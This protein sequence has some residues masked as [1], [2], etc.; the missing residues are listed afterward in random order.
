MLFVNWDGVN[1]PQFGWCLI[2]SKAQS[3]TRLETQLIDILREDQYVSL[4]IIVAD[5]GGKEVFSYRSHLSDGCAYLVRLHDAFTIIGP[6][7]KHDGLVLEVM[8]PNLSEL[9]HKRP[10]FQVGEPW[11]RRFTTAFAKRALLD[12]L[13]ALDFLHQRD[14]VHGDLHFGNILTCIGQLKVSPETES[15]LQQSVSEGHP[16]V[17]KDG[18]RDLW[19]PSH[20]LEPRPLHEYFSDELQP[21]V[22]LADLGGGKSLKKNVSPIA[23]IKLI[24]YK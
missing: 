2:H 4:K 6:N 7:G 21:L 16:L 15:K 13:K 14:V 11:E 5:C 20:L 12:T 1:S 24:M 17:R 8:G 3:H 22:K 19:A 9:L 23:H 10:E 18:K